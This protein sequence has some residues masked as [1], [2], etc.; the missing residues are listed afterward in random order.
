MP[1][2]TYKSLTRKKKAVKQFRR[3]S[4]TFRH[5]KNL[6]QKKNLRQKI[7]VKKLYT[8][9]KR[10]G[11]RFTRVARG[12]VDDL[13][14]KE[15]YANTQECSICLEE[16][17]DDE[18]TVL[19]CNH[20][21]H[22][23]CLKDA[24]QTVNL[25]CP[26]CRKPIGGEISRTLLTES[27]QDMLIVAKAVLI[28]A[29]ATVVE[30]EAAVV[31]ADAI[32][33]TR[34]QELREAT[35]S[36]RMAMRKLSAAPSK[37]AIKA[38]D[39]AAAA[40]VT[41][42]QAASAAAEAAVTK[43]EGWEAGWAAAEEASAAVMRAEEAVNVAREEERLAAERTARF[44]ESQVLAARFEALRAAAAERAGSSA[45]NHGT[46]TLQEVLRGANSM[47]R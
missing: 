2:S 32:V 3:G 47:R 42:E 25:V 14:A 15:N 33:K 46:Y 40:T 24:L 23:R 35:A 26:L 38:A 45:T 17:T 10:K 28:E 29:E 21:F 16:M 1:S 31:E 9:D 7:S 20:K 6:K 37:A 39:E 18:A 22:T 30:A 11:K 36:M 13:R 8:K 41:A 34:L 12:F 5:K 27:P 43:V 4:K 44:E 19:K